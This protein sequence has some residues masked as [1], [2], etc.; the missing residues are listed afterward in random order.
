MAKSEWIDMRPRRKCREK[1]SPK[2]GYQGDKKPSPMAGCRRERSSVDQGQ[3]VGGDRV[4]LCSSLP[5]WIFESS[6]DE[7]HA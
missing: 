6:A 3:A 7:G 1:S 4:E 5:L 2:A